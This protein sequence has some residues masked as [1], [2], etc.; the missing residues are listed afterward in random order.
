MIPRSLQ[1]SLLLVFV[2]GAMCS[3][4][5]PEQATFA[6]EEH[7]ETGYCSEC[8]S[9]DFVSG[10]RFLE[11]DNFHQDPGG[12]P[13]DFRTVMWTGATTDNRVSETLPAFR[14][15]SL[16]LLHGVLRT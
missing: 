4:I 5:C 6:L 13:D 11:G 9:T 12:L 3:V 10:E 15:R 14:P 1:V 8:I 16:F 2:I 7:P